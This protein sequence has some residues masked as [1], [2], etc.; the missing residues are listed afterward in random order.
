MIT[1]VLAIEHLFLEPPPPVTIVTIATIGSKM[2]KI[3]N[4]ELSQVFVTIRDCHRVPVGGPGIAEK[5]KG[6]GQT[7]SPVRRIGR[8]TSRRFL[9]PVPLPSAPASRASRLSAQPAPPSPRA[10]FELE[11]YRL[12]ARRRESGTLQHSRR[13]LTYYGYLVTDN[14]KPIT[15]ITPEISRKRGFCP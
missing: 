10:G 13:W 1:K 3:N 7:A 14:P 12:A 8:R 2:L 15:P 6:R 11:R 4:I 9:L 5:R